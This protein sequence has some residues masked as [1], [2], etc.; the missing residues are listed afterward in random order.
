MY[1]L[2]AKF[3]VTTLQLRLHRQRKERTLS[4]GSICGAARFVSMLRDCFDQHGA[5][6]SNAV[7]ARYRD[8]TFRASRRLCSASLVPRF[9]CDDR[10]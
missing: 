1:C 3:P 8:Q 6:E 2:S 4:S 7:D 5:P 9:L 10:E